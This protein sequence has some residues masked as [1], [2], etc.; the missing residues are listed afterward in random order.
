MWVKLCILCRE[1]S[2][3]IRIAVSRSWTSLGYGFQNGF[4]KCMG[5]W[6]PYLESFGL[7][8]MDRIHAINFV[9]KAPTCFYLFTCLLCLCTTFHYYQMFLQTVRWKLL[10]PIAKE[11]SLCANKPVR[12]ATFVSSCILY[13]LCFKVSQSKNFVLTIA[14]W[15]LSDQ[16]EEDHS[17]GHFSATGFGDGDTDY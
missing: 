6:N 1:T 2:Q 16:E 5:G 4:G 14:S 17:V 8:W 13:K 11:S 12:T 7:V 3:S 15:T 9:A 10:R